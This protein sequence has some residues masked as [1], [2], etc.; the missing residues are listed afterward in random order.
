MRLNDVEQICLVIA[1]LYLIES[2]S[3]VRRGAVTFSS[4]AG[5]FPSFWQ[6]FSPLSNEVGRVVLAG[7][8]P[9]DASFV[10]QAIPVSVTA[11][12]V[13]GF[14]AQ[15]PTEIRRPQQFERFFDWQALGEVRA[16]D[17]QVRVHGD[18]LCIVHSENSARQL[19]GR[20]AVLAAMDPAE[21]AR[22]INDW[23]WSDFDLTGTVARIETF[24]AGTTRL[25]RTAMALF[26]WLLP[27]GLL[28]HYGVI[29]GISRPSVL[30]AYLAITF[31]LWWW[32][33]R[34][35]WQCHR[36]LFPEG[37]RGCFRLAVTGLISP[38]VALRA[39]NHLARELFEF[40][41]PATLAAALLAEPAF[42]EFAGRV[43][44]DMEHHACPHVPSCAGTK[45]H[46][47]RA[48]AI[49]AEHTARNR[50]FF[51]NLLAQTSIEISDLQTVPVGAAAGV[52]AWCP[53]CLSEF[54]LAEASCPDC[55]DRPMARIEFPPPR[56]DH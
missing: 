50:R 41:H 8:L 12:G 13:V 35:A 40:L 49:V 46:V 21:R 56:T 29:P 19:V 28:L 9:G 14:L 32:T 33:V 38:G 20:L 48:A 30:T 16:T 7:P 54:A 27:V 39:G 25:R 1:V 42:R 23:I 43:W 55:G 26:V 5:R 18:L 22:H 2:C 52:A 24:R 44:R 47:A 4:F 37:R 3:W 17:R 15:S 51:L 11:D 6:R 36:R 10:C 31:A 34:N 53:R 45:G